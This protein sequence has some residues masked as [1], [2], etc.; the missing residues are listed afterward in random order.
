MKSRVI[1]LGRFDVCLYPSASMNGMTTKNGRGIAR[2]IS[3]S[4]G[5]G[6]ISA[7]WSKA[8]NTQHSIFIPYMVISK[9]LFFTENRLFSM[10]MPSSRASGAYF[11]M[12]R[13]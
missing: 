12:W 11:H 8:M 10:F 5:D 7:A 9:R 1:Y 6:T 4:F 13:T 3:E 2:S